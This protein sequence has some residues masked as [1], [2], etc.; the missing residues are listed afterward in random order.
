MKTL[1][2]ILVSLIGCKP[3]ELE[4]IEN[5]NAHTGEA[6]IVLEPVGVIPA[7]DCQQIAL[8]DKACNFRLTDQDGNTWDLYQHEGDVIVLDFS[9]FWCY[10]CQMAAEHSQDIQDSYT[11]VQMVTILIDGNTPGLE[12]TEEEVN[13][14]STNHGITTA[15]VLKGSREKM[16]DPA[17]IEGYSLSGF[18]TYLYI[19]KELKFYAGH[20]GFNDEYTRLKIE[21]GL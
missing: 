18:P 15:P 16:F 8:G 17:A 14:W 10:P 11:D 4:T 5:V 3:S 9:A 13:Q 6:E 1:F 19:D 2:F 21:E 12:P 20:T 7:D